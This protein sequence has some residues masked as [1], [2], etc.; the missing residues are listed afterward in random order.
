MRRRWPSHRAAQVC[1]QS[2]RYSQGDTAYLYRL[3]LYHNLRIAEFWR[4]LEKSVSR[5][6]L[7]WAVSAA[8][9]LLAE[10]G[11]L[12]LVCVL[13]RSRGGGPHSE[14]WAGAIVLGE[15]RGGGGGGCCS[16]RGA[17]A[18]GTCGAAGWGR[19]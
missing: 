7:N 14:R 17:T 11:P 9:Q 3:Q 2:G 19:S 4:I 13:I 18:V 12:I 5:S 8:E 10:A 16:L 1:S 15:E 6:S